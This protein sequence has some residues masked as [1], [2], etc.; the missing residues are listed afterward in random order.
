MTKMQ[1]LNIKS[2]NIYGN[3][4]RLIILWRNRTTNDVKPPIEGHEN[5]SKFKGQF[6]FVLEI[7]VEK[8]PCTYF[9]DNLYFQRKHDL[10]SFKFFQFPFLVG[11]NHP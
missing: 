10:I 4:E 7:D 3:Y 1:V 8:K 2:Q 9:I 11:K 6:S 5:K